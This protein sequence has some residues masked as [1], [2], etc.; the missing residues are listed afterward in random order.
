METDFIVGIDIGS[1]R[2]RVLISE[3]C[4]SGEMKIVAAA[5]NPTEGVKKGRITDERSVSEV[6]RLTKL[7]AEKMSGVEVEG[8]CVSFSNSDIRCFDS[9]GMLTLPGNREVTEADAE[10]VSGNARKVPLPSDR[11]I[12][13]TIEQYF[14]IDGETDIVDPVGRR[15]A[16]LEKNLHIVTATKDHYDKLAAVLRWNHIELIDLTF[17]PFAAARVVLSKEEIESGSV[18]VEIGAEVTSYA[19]Y[20]GG[21]VRSS[22]VLPV[23]GFNVSNDMSIGMG[24]PFEVAEAFKKEFGVEREPKDSGNEM[25]I[26]QVTVGGSSYSVEREAAWKIAAPR[27]E[28]L[29]SLIREDLSH[30]P[31]YDR[32]EVMVF[33]SGGGSSLKGV[34]PVTAGVLGTVSSG[35]VPVGFTGLSEMM[36]DESW[37]VAAGLLRVGKEKLEE[38]YGSGEEGYLKW[39]LQGIKKVV[40]TF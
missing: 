27:C 9:Q 31:Y 34:R 30:D 33:L 3:V 39:V 18:L 21:I 26:V 36:E 29:F 28:E 2:T 1:S 20:R 40:N 38:G 17:A 14:S 8:A 22:G 25:G 4:E 6:L 13:H 11:R 19:L 16:R 7:E 37:N 10:H 12:L 5:S 15:G 23:G 32:S 35:A 24:L